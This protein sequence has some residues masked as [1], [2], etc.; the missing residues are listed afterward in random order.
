MAQ[1]IDS[2]VVKF[3][4]LWKAGRNAN[5]TLKVNAGKAEINLCV[6][7]ID[8]LPHIP[9]PYPRQSRNGP[10]QQRRRE[11]RALARQ[12]AEE[13]SGETNVVDEVAVEASAKNVTAV[14]SSKSVVTE[15]QSSSNPNKS[16]EEVDPVEVSDE[17]CSNADY[18]ENESSSRNAKVK[19]F[20]VLGE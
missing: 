9:F 15:D 16:S 8:E 12:Q 5:L 6:K 20:S 7:D 1:E 11:K 10:A 18:V 19:H 4:N 14:D 17:F 3:K 13:A 2:S